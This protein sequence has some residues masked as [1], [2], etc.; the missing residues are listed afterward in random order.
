[1]CDKKEHFYITFIFFCSIFLLVFIP[2][3][4]LRYVST[5]LRGWYPFL[6]RI[7]SR[8]LHSVGMLG[9]NLHILSNG[10]TANVDFSAS[11]SSIKLTGSR[12]RLQMF[13]LMPQMLNWIES[14]CLGSLLQ[15]SWIYCHVHRAVPGQS[16]S[17]S[18]GYYPAE[19]I[20]PQHCLHAVRGC[21]WLARVV[22][23]PVALNHHISFIKGPNMCH[24]GGGKK[25]CT[26]LCLSLMCGM[27]DAC[28]GWCMWIFLHGLFISLEQCEPGFIRVSNHRVKWFHPVVQW[29]HRKSLHSNKCSS[30]Q[31]CAGLW[32]GSLLLVY[33]KMN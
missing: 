10:F 8:P 28:V 12:S 15:W 3:Y 21:T 30:G 4:Y 31:R 32:V 5:T 7:P 24:G 29:R 33:R 27:I 9:N 16:C 2:I 26:S 19:K 1:M 6:V 18:M 17:C 22:W 20:L 13:N 25:G 23:Y 14:V 11:H